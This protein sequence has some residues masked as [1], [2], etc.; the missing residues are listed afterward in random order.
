MINVT[1]LIHDTK[2]D[3]GIIR[4]PAGELLPEL[5]ELLRGGGCGISGIAD[6]TSSK[7]LLRGVIVPHI[8]MRIQNGISALGHSDVINSIRKETIVLYK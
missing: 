6:Y 4:E 2:N 3:I 7:W 5:A 8:V 1:Y